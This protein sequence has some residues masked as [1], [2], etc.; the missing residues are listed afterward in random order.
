MAFTRSS[1]SSAVIPCSWASIHPRQFLGLPELPRGG[2]ILLGQLGL[3]APFAADGPHDLQRVPLPGHNGGSGPVPVGVQLFEPQQL[4]QGP[5]GLGSVTRPC[6]YDLHSS[7]AH[8]VFSMPAA[9]GDLHGPDP[10][11]GYGSIDLQPVLGGVDH[12][13]GGIND[14]LRGAVVLQHRLGPGAVVLLEFPDVPGG[15]A[16]ESVDVLVIVAHGEEVEPPARLPPG[17]SCQCRYEVVCVLIDVLVLV[18]EQPS[19]AGKELLPSARRRPRGLHP[20]PPGTGLPPGGSAGI[21]CRR[22]AHFLRWSSGR[23]GR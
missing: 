19:E 8:R 17:A 2:E 13:I 7:L 3:Q 11:D 16:A 22:H 20:R 12:C 18:D 23:C 14:V 21:P 5:V 15:G 9:A 6:G 4:V 10:V 1:A